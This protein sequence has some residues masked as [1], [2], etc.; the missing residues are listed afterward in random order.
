[1][2]VHGQYVYVVNNGGNSVS[3]YSIGPGGAL[4]AVPNS[5]FGT[6]AFAN[7]V[8]VDRTSHFVYVASDSDND[9][10][11]YSIGSGGTLTLVTEFVDPELRFTP[12]CVTASPK[13]DFVYATSLDYTLRAFSIGTDGKLTP[14]GPPLAT[15]FYPTCVAFD[16]KGHFAYVTNQGDNTVS[17]Y[18]S[19]G[20]GVLTEVSGSPFSTE[21]RSPVAV[22]L[23]SRFLFVLSG[24][25]L[26]E[27]GFKG[28]KRTVSVYLRGP[29]DELTAAAGSPYQLPSVGLALAIDPK[30]QFLYVTSDGYISG[31]RINLNGTLT[32]VPGSP[33]PAADFPLGIAADPSGRFVYVVNFVANN[34]SGYTIATDGSLTAMPTS[35]FASGQVPVAIAISNAIP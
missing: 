26:F 6:A 8:T 29:H 3:G 22:V 34:I 15:G 2:P 1:M 25:S 30:E 28:N 24:Q 19:R 18:K 31:F 35:P 12:L 20:N 13:R 32:A 9:I 7:S 33:F 17:E 23:S 10:V 11:G 5:P 27:P 21:R 14:F 4:I 16:P